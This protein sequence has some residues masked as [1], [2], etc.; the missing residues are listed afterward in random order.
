M[1]RFNTAFLPGSADLE[2]AAA[3]FQKHFVGFNPVNNP[4]VLAQR[5]PGE[6]F[7]LTAS[8]GKCNCGTPLGSRDHRQSET[9]AE[10]DRQI[11]KL[12]KRGWSAAKIER[13]Q[14]QK[15]TAEQKRQRVEHGYAES[16][17]PHLNQWI[18]LITELL[19]SGTTERVGLLL[20]WGHDVEDG[21]FEI[22]RQE[23]VRLQDLTVEHLLHLEEEVLYQY[24]V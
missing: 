11:A 4:R 9:Q 17:T 8:S 3:I 13:W 18:N 2:T 15:Q 24:R 5:P 10:L 14:E 16:V 6:V 22:E 20:H 12:R 21:G 7:I 19:H 1:C 23:W